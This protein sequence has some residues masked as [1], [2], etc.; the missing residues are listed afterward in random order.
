[1][2]SGPLHRNRARASGREVLHARGS[3]LTMAASRPRLLP[4]ST[5][6]SA[7][8]EHGRRPSLYAACVGVLAA[9]CLLTAVLPAQEPAFPPADRVS[10]EQADIAA[11]SGV[12]Q[13]ELQRL[14]AEAAANRNR[15]PSQPDPRFGNSLNFLALLLEGGALMIPIGIM[16]LL[17]VAVAL[18]RFIALRG[19]KLFPRGLRRELRSARDSEP[20]A[21]YELY[22]AT[23]RFPS[24][25]GRVLRDMLSKGGRPVPEVEAVIAESTQRE[26]DA[27]Y[28]NVRWLTLAAAVTPLIGLLGTVWGMIIAFYNTTQLGAG[29]NKAEFLAEGIYVALVTTLGGLAVAIPAAIFAHYFEGR[30]TKMLAQVAGELRQLLPRFESAE[31][32]QRFELGPGGLIRRELWNEAAR[33]PPKLDSAA[34]T[35]T[36]AAT[37]RPVKNVES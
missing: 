7:G 18:E 4:W 12:E 11:E 9:W 26:A 33:R 10:A 2:P 36:G 15:G 25:A 35:R 1:M 13:Q 5:Y 32:K 30:I 16:S 20:L 19:S 27:L 31:G 21:A 17:V 23:E 14:A 8:A 6:A 24:A 3:A 34:A 29:T 28:S 37:A 22:Q